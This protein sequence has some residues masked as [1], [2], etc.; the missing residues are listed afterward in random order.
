LR[1]RFGVPQ[2][3]RTARVALDEVASATFVCA[4]RATTRCG[5]DGSSE[6]T[7]SP[8]RRRAGRL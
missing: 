2:R 1:Q 3:D 8:C 4:A 7:S 6:I 5:R